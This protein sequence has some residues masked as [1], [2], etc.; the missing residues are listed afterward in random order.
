MFNFAG[1]MSNVK[2]LRCD[3]S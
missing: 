2:D 3:R 1:E